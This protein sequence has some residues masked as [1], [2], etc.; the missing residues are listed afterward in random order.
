MRAARYKFKYMGNLYRNMRNVLD[1]I[2]MEKK[3]DTNHEQLVYPLT[4]IRGG[5][6]R[7]C[8]F[9]S[10]EI[11]ESSSAREAFYRAVIGSQSGVDGLGGGDMW[12]SK[13]AVVAPSK[14]KDAD[15]DYTFIQVS[16]FGDGKLTFNANCGNISAGVPLFALD[17]KMVT[18]PDGL[19]TMRIWNTNTQKLMLAELQVI[20][21][22]A[23]VHGNYQIAGVPGTGSKIFMDYQYT[24][25]A[26]TNRAFP[27]GNTVDTIEMESGTNIDV[28][29]CDIANL[30]VFV[31]AADLNYKGT[32][33]PVELSKSKELFQVCKEIRGKA[34]KLAGLVKHWQDGQMLFL[35]P[36]CL[37]ASPTDYTTTDAQRIKASQFT[38]SGRIIAVEVVHDAF[39]GTGACCLAAA[40][41]VSGTIPNQLIKNHT[42]PAVLK[43][44]HPGGIMPVEVSIIPNV[45]CNAIKFNRLGLGRTARKISEGVIYIKT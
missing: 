22:V 19:N 34:A 12:N 17:Q 32:E 25:G 20:N 1:I 21:N 40:S 31:K 2:D 3:F 36:V 11:P 42:V 23:V 37:V 8:F 45:N 30:L 24:L 9:N 15:V 16:P 41:A 26:V 44:G 4:I 10:D 14:R 43:I 6:S 39:M 5:T 29:I 28:T 13:I 35:P 33:L 27:T 18:F 7:A 38:L